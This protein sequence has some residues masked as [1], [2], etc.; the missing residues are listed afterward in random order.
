MCN[1]NKSKFLKNQETRGLLSSLGIKSKKSNSFVRSYFVL[2]YKMN[3]TVNIFLL[4]GDKFIPKMHLRHPR[5]I[6]S[7][8]G[9]FKKN[10]INKIKK[11]TK[12]EDSRY[13]YRKKLFCFQHDMVYGDSKDLE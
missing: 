10:K 6:H 8:C 12:A 1:S 5:F 3:E 11:I 2:K 7:A 9:S 4:T 13:I